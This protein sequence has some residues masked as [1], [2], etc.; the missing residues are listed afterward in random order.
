MNA[1]IKCRAEY[2][3]IKDTPQ[4]EPLVDVVLNNNNTVVY[5]KVSVEIYG[6]HRYAPRKRS[7]GR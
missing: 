1:V 2:D 6:L 7:W 4:D 3:K 5:R